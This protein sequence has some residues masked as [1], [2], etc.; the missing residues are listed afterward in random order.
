MIAFYL[1]F[2][3]QATRSQRILPSIPLVDYITPL[4]HHRSLHGLP[5]GSWAPWLAG[6]FA[7]SIS[8]LILPHLSPYSSSR[9]SRPTNNLNL[10]YPV[11]TSSETRRHRAFLELYPPIVITDTILPVSALPSCRSTKKTCTSR[12]SECIRILSSLSRLRPAEP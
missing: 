11:E 6:L 3:Q 2:P 8:P 1:Y 7:C 12:F 4:S 10:L 5:S 9:S